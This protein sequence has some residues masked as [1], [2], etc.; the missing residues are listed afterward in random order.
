MNCS[1]IAEV[2]LLC[3][4][5]CT[6]GAHVCYSLLPDDYIQCILFFSINEH[7]KCDIQRC[8]SFSEQ[9]FVQDEESEVASDLWTEEVVSC[10]IPPYTIK[11]RPLIQN[12]SLK[13]SLLY[14]STLPLIE[15]PQ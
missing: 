11:C 8:L 9:K 1:T 6:A 13:P 7:Q 4:G 15:R 2:E 3:Y 10:I 14:L 12:V 5:A